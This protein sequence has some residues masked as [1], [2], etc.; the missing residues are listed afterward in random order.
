MKKKSHVLN[1]ILPLLTISAVVLLWAVSSAII[2]SEYI[3][4]SVMDT[5]SSALAVLGTGEFYRALIDTLWRCVIAFAVSFLVGGACAF[6]SSRFDVVRRCAQPI[7]SIL[8]AMPTIAI[9]LLLLFWTNS[10]IAPIIVTVLVVLPTVYSQLKYAFDTVDKSAKEASMVDG[11]GAREVFRFI[12]LPLISPAIFSTVGSGFTLNL[13]L[14]VAAEVIA[15][16]AN[17]IGY[18]LNTSKVY[19]EIADMLAL[20]LITIVLG[21]IIESV[22]EFISKRTK[23]WE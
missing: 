17:S 14:M 6:L 4:P 12:E 5:L 13:K 10:H 23:D 18:M 15:Q 2:D 22:F 21:V 9:V 3:L 1:L 20:V 16:T 11:A 8:R 19:F 7:I